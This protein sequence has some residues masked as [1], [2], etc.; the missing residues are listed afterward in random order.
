VSGFV[1]ATKLLVG[2][3]PVLPAMPRRALFA[4]NGLV[5]RLCEALPR[6]SPQVKSA[7][8]FRPRSTMKNEWI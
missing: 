2:V 8:F 4:L 5:Q 1:D 7:V 3:H 6:G